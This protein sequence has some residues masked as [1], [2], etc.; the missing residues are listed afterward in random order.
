MVGVAADCCDGTDE[1]AGRC[2]HTCAQ[3]GQA[4]REQLQTAAKSAA[5]GYK[6]TTM[7][8]GGRML[9]ASEN[10]TGH[11]KNMHGGMTCSLQPAA[12]VCVIYTLSASAE[13]AHAD[14][15][16]AECAWL[17]KVCGAFPVICTTTVFIEANSQL[18][19]V[20]SPGAGAEAAHSRCP[21][22]QGALGGAAG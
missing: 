22:D 11:L 18:T 15:S 13:E 1:A 2:K 19:V 14:C 4:A 20:A 17:C 10:E 3:Q 9:L 8:R 12:C 16:R 5:A 21:E 7:R 6:V